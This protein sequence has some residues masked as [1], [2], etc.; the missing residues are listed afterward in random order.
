MCKLSKTAWRVSLT[1]REEKIWRSSLINHQ[2]AQ[3]CST[4]PCIPD[5]GEAKS[6]SLHGMVDGLNLEPMR[7]TRWRDGTN[8][9]AP[10]TSGIAIASYR[11]ARISLHV[12]QDEVLFDVSGFHARASTKTRDS[13][14]VISLLLQAGYSNIKKRLNDKKAPPKVAAEA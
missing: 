11:I 1:Q 2:S 14:A 13:S 8:K 4:S 10:L 7:S 3:H 6:M 9:H 12:F 5:P